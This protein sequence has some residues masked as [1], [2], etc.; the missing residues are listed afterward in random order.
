M[1]GQVLLSNIAEQSRRKS[2]KGGFSV[3]IPDESSCS[4]MDATQMEGLKILK[5]RSSNTMFCVEAA[6]VFT[7][8]PAC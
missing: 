3:K 7:H 5:V 1:E 8:H 6:L 4:S 2:L